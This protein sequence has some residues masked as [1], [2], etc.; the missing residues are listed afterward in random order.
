MASTTGYR[1]IEVPC[2]VCA[3][4]FDQRES[5]GIPKTCSPS[6]GATLRN[7]ARARRPITWQHEAVCPEC[8]TTFMQMN[9]GRPK[10][11]SRKCARTIEWKTRERKATMRHPSGYV[12]RYSPGHPYGTGTSSAYVL[13]HR[14]VME[15]ALGRVLAPD[16]R[17]HHKN[18]KRDDNRLE[19]LELWHV[20]RKDPAGI[21]QID[22]HCSGCRCFGT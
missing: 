18:G 2:P 19:N 6:C 8:G 4:K 10:T 21:R 12:W 17:V 1:T 16:E 22:Y 11:C 3:T 20:K 14:I 15:T 13:E 7:L 9:D 5:S